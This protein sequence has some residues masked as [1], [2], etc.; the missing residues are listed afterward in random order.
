MFFLMIHIRNYTGYVTYGSDSFENMKTIEVNAT[1]P[2]ASVF[3]RFSKHRPERCKD[4][5]LVISENEPVDFV[6]C[7]ETYENGT[8][9]S[10]AVLFKNFI[11]PEN[12]TIAENITTNRTG[13]NQ[14]INYTDNI[15]QENASLIINQTIPYINETN[16]TYDNFTEDINYTQNITI[17][18]PL[19]EGN[20]TNQTTN[21]SLPQINGTNETIPDNIRINDTAPTEPEEQLNESTTENETFIPDEQHQNQTGDS[22]YNESAEEPE[23]IEPAPSPAPNESATEAKEAQDDIL[24]GDEPAETQENESDPA[25]SITGQILSTMPLQKQKETRTYYIYY[26]KII[27]K[28]VLNETEIE[29][30]SE[31]Q[32]TAE[33]GKP[34]EWTKIIRAKN[35]NNRPVDINIEFETPTIADNIVATKKGEDAQLTINT[36]KVSGI[37]THS[38]K[39]F[40]HFTINDKL[41]AEQESHYKIKYYTPAPELSQDRP[42][43]SEAKWTKR[44][45]VTST[46]NIHYM[47]ILTHIYINET[48][49]A[50][51]KLYHIINNTKVE[52]TNSPLYNVQYIDTNNNAKIDKIS[53]LTPH[54]S[55]Q[56][57]EIEI[58]LTILNI[59]SYPTV[60]GNWTV[61]FNT[62]G[63]ANLTISAVNSTTWSSETEEHDLKFLQIKCGTR[64]LEYEWIN[65]FLFIENY[66]CNETAHET[67]KVLASGKHTLKFRFG[68]NIAYAQITGEKLALNLTAKKKHFKAGENPEFIFEYI[69]GKKKAKKALAAKPEKALKKWVTENETIETSVYYNE[70]L[71]DMQPEIER[72][73]EGEFSIKIPRKSAFRAGIYKLKVELEKNGKTYTEEQEF[74]WGVLAVNTGK[75]IYLPDEQAYIQMAALKDDGHTLCDANLALEI[76]SSDGTIEN[77]E[78]RKGECRLNNFDGKPDYFAYYLTSEVGIYQIKLTNLDTGYEIHDSFEVRHSV[79]FDIERIGPTRIYPPVTYEMRFIIKANQDFNGQI[80]EHVPESFEIIT[81][82]TTQIRT[83]N[84]TK[85]II[86]EV[87]WQAG[88]SYELSYRFKTPSISPYLYLLGPLSINSTGFKE[89]RQWH[90]AADAVERAT[91]VYGEGTVATP[92]YRIWDGTDLG[93]ELTG[94]TMAATIYWVVLKSGTTRDEKMLVAGTNAGNLYASVWNGASWTNKTLGSAILADATR[95]G[96]DIAY[97]K[98]SGDAM[99]VARSDNDIKYWVWNS[100]SWIVDG[101]V[102]TLTVTSGVPHWIKLASDPG[103]DEISMIWLDGTNS[104]A[105]GA[106]WNGSA[107]GSQQL[108]DNTNITAEMLG[109][110]ILAVEYEQ[111]SGYAMFVWGADDSPTTDDCAVEWRQ[112][113]GSAWAGEGA[114]VTIG[115]DTYPPFY[116]SLKPNPSDDQLMLAVVDDALDLNTVRWNGSAWDSPVE[117]DDAIETDTNRPADVEWET[118]SGHSGHAVCVWNT[119]D[120]ALQARHWNGTG[121]DTAFAT[122]PYAELTDQQIHQLR[123][124]ADDKIFAGMVDD[125]ADLHVWKWNESLTGPD[126]GNWIYSGNGLGEIE[127]DVSGGLLYE[128]FMWASDII[129]PDIT[130]SAGGS[131]ASEVYQ[132]TGDFELGGR[133]VI[134]HN[135]GNSTVT[136]IDI[137]EQGTIDAQ[138]ELSDVR[139]YYDL[140]TSDPYD[141]ASEEYNSSTDPQFGS[142]TTFNGADGNASF[143]NTGITINQTKTM[144]VYVVFDV[145]ADPTPGDTIDIQITN[146]PNYIT[147]GDSDTKLPNTPVAISGSTTI[148]AKVAKY[149]Q[150]AYIWEND[151]GNET[152]GVDDNTQQAGNNTAITS[153]RKGERVTLRVHLDVDE[154]AS[155]KDLALFYDRNDGIFTKVQDS[156][157]AV[158]GSGS[159][160]GSGASSN[161]DCSTVF[162]GDDTNDGRYTSIAFDPSGNAW[163]SFYDAATNDGHT[164]V[165]RYVGTGGTGCGSGITAWQCSIAYDGDTTNDG[166][167]TSIAIDPS[168]NPWVSLW[169]PYYTIVAQYVGTGGTGCGGTITDWNCTI[170]YYDLDTGDGSHTSI[171]ID[172][173]GNAWVSLRDYEVSGSHTVVARYVGSDGSGCGDSASDA[174]NCT[175]VDDRGSTDNSQYT[176]IAFDPSGNA[177]VSFWDAGLDGTVVAQYVGTGGQNCGAG[178]SDAW[179]CSVAYDGDATNDGTYTAIAFDPSGNAWVS[180]YDDSINGT[181]VAKYVGSGGTDCGGTITDWN[182]TTAWNGTSGGSYTS[183]AFDPSGN[184]WVS[185][186]DA[187]INGTVVAKYVGSGGTGCGGTITEWSCTTAWNGTSGGTHTSIAFDPSGNAWVSLH[188]SGIN[189]TVVAKIHRGGEI[190]TS[191]GLAGANG[192]NISESHA[193]M[194]STSDTTNRDDA[195]CIDGTSTWVNGKWFESEEGQGGLTSVSAGKCTEVAFTLDTSQAVAGQ[196]YRFIVSLQDPWRKDKSPW[197]G[198]ESIVNYATLT[199]EDPTA[200]R[201]SKDNIARFGTC[202][203]GASADWGCDTVFDGSDTD[204]GQYT[205]IAFDPSGNAWV[206][207]YDNATD[208]GHTVVAQYVGTGGTGCGGT[209]NN[210]DCSVAFDGE[211]SWDG[212]Y[213][214]I[215][216]D[217]SG[218]AWVSL[219]DDSQEDI[220]V[221]RYVGSG[222]QNCGAGASDA[223]DC[224]IAYDGDDGAGHT[225]I[226]FDPSGNAWVSLWGTGEAIVARYVGSGGSGCGTGASEAW[227]CSI[228]YD[229]A[230]STACQYTSIAFDPSGNAWVSFHDI[231]TNEGHTVVA[232]Y[233]GS[234]GTG[235]GSGASD[236]WN[237]TVAF[238]GVDFWDGA[239]TSIAF[240]PSG[241]AWVSLHDDSQ[242]DTI[243]ARYVGSGGQNCGAGASDAWNCTIAF[244]STSSGGTSTSIAFDPSGNAWVSLYRDG[245]V[246]ARYVGTGGTGC[247]TGITDWNCTTVWNGTSGGQYTSIA[248]DPS[249]NAWVSLHDSGIDG[250]VV[251]KLNAPHYKNDIR[252]LSDNDGQG[253]IASDNSVRDPITARKDERPFYFL[254]KRTIDNTRTLPVSWNGQST[255]APSSKSIGLQ[256]YRFGSTN[257]WE[258]ITPTVNTCSSAGANTDCDISGSPGGT[259]SEYYEADGSYYY[260][261][262][263]RVFQEKNGTSAETFKTDRFEAGWLDVTV[264]TYRNSSYSETDKFFDRQQTIYVEANVTDSGNN[265]TDATVIANFTINGVVEN[266]TTLTHYSG[267]SYR[268]NWATNSTSTVGVYNVTVRANNSVGS[269]TASNS[270][271]LY[272]G[273]NVSAYRMDWSEDGVNESIMENKHLIVA[274][275]ETENTDKL[276]LYLEQKDTNVSYTFGTLSDGNAT[277]SGGITTDN[278]TTRKYSSFSFTSE[279]ENLGS[280]DYRFNANLY[281]SGTTTYKLTDTTNNKAW[282]NTI[283]DASPPDYGTGTEF[284]GNAY[285][286]VTTSNDE[287]AS[288]GLLVGAEGDWYATHNF[289]FHINE[290]ISSI[291]NFTI[292]WEGKYSANAFS[293]KLQVKNQTS[294]G[295]ININ[296][297]TA[298]DTTYTKEVTSNFEDYIN[299]STGNISIRAYGYDVGVEA[300]PKIDTDF[301]KIDVTTGPDVTTSFNSTI[302]MRDED[303]DYLVYTLL[304]FDLN[305]QNI[306]DIWSDLAGTLGSSVSDDRYHLEDGT[307]GLVSSLTKDQWSNYATQSNYS[308]IYDNS[309]SSDAVNDSVIAWVRFNESENITF[310][311]AGLWNDSTYN[312]GGFRIR[313]NTTNA[314][315]ADEVNYILAFT[316]GYWKTVDRWMPTIEAGNF[317][318]VNFMTA[319]PESTPPSVTNIIITPQK[320]SNGTVLKINVTVTDSSNVSVVKAGIY[321]PNGTLW[322]NLI[323]GNETVDVYNCS[324]TAQF[325]PHGTYNVTIWANDTLNN[326]NNTEKSWFTPYLIL[327]DSQNITI[328]G[329][330]GDWVGVKNVS[331][332]LADVAITAVYDVSSISAGGYHTCGILSSGS[333]YCW[334]RGRYGRL[335]DGNIGIHSEGNPVAVTM[336]PN[337]FTAITG[338]EY[339]TCGILSNGSAYCW[340]RGES[341][342]LGDGNYHH[343]GNP[344]AVNITP[345][346]FTPITGGKYHTCGILSNGSAYCWGYGG[347]GQLGDGNT[348]AHDEGNPV[349]VNI[350]LNNFTSISAGYYHTCGILSNGSAYCWGYGGFGQLGDGDFDSEG[351]PVPVNMTP[352]NFTA[353]TGGKYYTCG[354]LSN[355][356]AY[357]WGQGDFGQLGDGNTSAHNEGN[358]VP[359]NMTPNNFTAI[360]A[361]YYHT[362]GILSNGS[363]YCWGQGEYGQLGDGNTSDHDEGNPVPVNSSAFEY[364][365]SSFDL[366]TISL[367]NNNTHLFALI[368]VDGI[369][370]YSNSTEYYRLFISKNDSS[371]NET[372]PE[373]DTNLSVKYDYRVQVNG[374]VCYIYNSTDISNNISGCSFSSNSD[375]IELA[376]LLTDLNITTG[377]NINVT[378]ESGSS[379]QSYDFAPDYRSFLSYGVAATVTDGTP[380]SVTNIIITPQKV[381]NGTVLEINATVTDSS[382]VSVVKAGIYYPNGTLWQN[383]I[384]S[385]ET[386]DVYNCSLTAEFYP[387]GTYN[388]TLW[389]N[390]TLNNINN[391]EKT[392]LTPYLDL[393]D[394]HDIT[395]NG[396][397]E[398]W[399]GVKNVSDIIGDSD[400]PAEEVEGFNFTSISAGSSHSCGVLANGSAYCWGYGDDGQLGYGG[401]DQ[402]EN[403]VAVNITL[404][405]FT[406]ISA[407]YEHSCGVLANGSAYCWGK[408]LNGR[409]GY[410]GTGQ[411]ENPVAVNITPNNF[412]G[413]SAGKYHSCGILSN[414]SAYCW[415]KGLNGQ[416]GCGETGQRENPVA[417]NITPNNFTSISAGDY[418]SCGVL[419]NGSAYC[420]GQGGYGRLGYGG[421]DQHENPVAVNITPN[422]FTRISAGQYHSCGVL[423]NGSAYCWGY[424]GNGQLGYGGTSQHENP[425]AVNISPNNFTGIF[426]GD[427]HSCGVLANGSAYCWGKGDDGRL[428]YGGISQHNN[429]VAVNI[430]P[431]NF[432]RICAGWSHSCG[433]LANGSAYCW[434]Y[435]LYGRLGDGSKGYVE[436]P[437]AVSFDYPTTYDFGLSAI[438]LANNDTHLFALI[439]VNGSLDYSNST[440]Y[441]RLFISKN[442]STGNETTPE[443]NTNLAIRYDY[444]V[445]VNGSV[446]YVYN[447]TDISNNISGCSFSNNSDTI[448]LAVLLT[449]L[450]I[451]TGDN[452][453]VT[454]ETGSSTQSYDFAPDYRSF[455][456]YDVILSAANISL[457]LSPNS[458]TSGTDVYI[459]GKVN[460][461][462]GNNASNNQIYIYLNNSLLGFNNLTLHGSYQELQNTEDYTTF[463]LGIYNNTVLNNTQIILNTTSVDDYS[464]ELSAVSHDGEIYIGNF[465]RVASDP[466]SNETIMVTVDEFGKTVSTVWN[467]SVWGNLLEIE[468]ST[469][470]TPTRVNP[471]DIVY[472]NQSRAMIVWTDN[473]A[474]P[475]YRLW[476]GTDYSDEASAQSTGS[477]PYNIYLA[478]KPDSTEMVL[479]TSDNAYDINVQ[480]WNGSGWGN[481][482]EIETDSGYHWDSPADVVYINATDAMIAYSDSTNITKYRL[483]N[484]TDAGT[485]QNALD[486]GPSATDPDFVRLASDP[487]SDEIIMAI[488]DDGRDINIQTWCGSGWGNLLELETS[489]VSADYNP[490]D[491]IYDNQS[492]AM[493]VWTD[494]TTTPKYRLWN[495]T[496]YNDEA[497]AQ[498]AGSTVYN[499][500]LASKPDS[501]DMVL[502]TSDNANDINVQTWNG[503]EWGNLVEIETDSGDFYDSPADVV[504]DNNSMAMIAYSDSTTTPKYRTIPY[505]E[506]VSSGNFTSQVIDAIVKVNWTSAGWYNNSPSLTSISLQARS[507]DDSSCSGESFAGPDGTS[508]SYYTNDISSELNASINRYFQFIAYF[509]TSDQSQTPQLSSV[510][511]NYSSTVTDAD[512][513]FNYSLD[514]S[515]LDTGNYTVKVNT[516]Y[517]ESYAENSKT[518]EIVVGNPPIITI[519]SPE[520]K[521]YNSQSIW[522]NVTL[523]EPGDWCGY[524]LDATPNITMTNS[525]GNWNNLTTVDEGS[526]NVTFSCN[527]TAGNMNS[528]AITEYFTVD[529]TYPKYSLNQTNSTEAG[530]DTLFSLYWTDNIALAGYIFSFDN[531]TGTFNND[532]YIEMTGA[533]NWSNAT[534]TINTTVDTTIRWI[535]YANDTADNM[536]ISDTYTFQTTPDQTAPTITIHEPQNNTITNDNTPLLNAS[537]SDTNPGS[538]WYSLDSGLNKTSGCSS[539]SCIV[540]NLTNNAWYHSDW[541]YRKNISISNTAGNQTDY[542]V[543]INLSSS[544]FNFSRA[545]SDGNDTRITYYNSTTETE[546]EILHWLELWNSTANTSAIWAKIPFIENNTNTTIYMYYGNAG[547]SSASNGTNTFLHFDDA[548]SD[549]SADY[550]YVGQPETGTVAGA[551]TLNWNAGGYY[552]L[553]F[554]DQIGYALIGSAP[555]DVEIQAEFW[556]PT[557]QDNNNPQPGLCLRHSTTDCYLIRGFTNG[558]DHASLIYATGSSGSYVDTDTPTLSLDKWQRFTI[559]AYGNNFTGEIYNIDDEVVEST[560]SGTSSDKSAAGDV[561]FYAAF[562]TETD[563]WK[564]RNLRVR[565]YT[566]P[567]PTASVGSEDSSGNYTLSDGI[568]N[569]TVYANDA[570]GNLNST[571]H[572]F[573]V[574]TQAPEVTLIAPENNAYESTSQI[575]FQYTPTDNIALAN[576]SIW[577][578]STEEWQ[579]N[580]TDPT[581]QNA[582]QNTT[583][584]TLADGTYIWNVQCYD[585]ASNAAFNETNY[586]LTVDTQAPQI[587]ITFPTNTTHATTSLHLNFTSTEWPLDTCWFELNG[588][589]TNI[590]IENC[591]NG[592]QFTANEGQNNITLWANDSANNVAQDTE[593]FTVSTIDIK[594]TRYFQPDTIITGEN[595]TIN[596]TTTVQVNKTSNNVTAINITDEIPYDFTPPANTTVTVWFIDASDASHKTNITSGAIIN[597][598]TRQGTNNTWLNITI[599]NI[600]ESGAPTPLQENDSIEL[601]Y[602]MTSSKL[603]IDEYRTMYTNA[604]AQ[605]IENN[606]KQSGITKNITAAENFL[607]AYKEIWHPDLSAPAN[608][609]VRIHILS[610]G[611]PLTEILLADYLPQGAAITSTTVTYYNKTNDQTHS[612]YNDTDYYL[613]PPTQD[614]LPCGTPADI[615]HYNFSYNFTSWDGWLYNNDTIIIEYN[616]TVLGGGEWILPAILG[617]FDP[618][619]K[620]YL[621][622]E[623]YTS[624]SVPS[625]DVVLEMLTDVIQKGDIAKAILRILNV[626]GPKAKVDVFV[627]YSIKDFNGNMLNEKSETIAVVETKEREIQLM[628]PKDIKPGMYS[629]EALVTYTQREAMTTSTFRIEGEEE[630][631][632]T[633]KYGIGLIAIAALLIIALIAFLL[634]RTTIVIQKK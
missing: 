385:N 499:I 380:P 632:F 417:V 138:N 392:W 17:P 192:D 7:N 433:V 79:P 342:Q 395:I 159:G 177:W 258:N 211:N 238:T 170:A 412:T 466:N 319:P 205:S 344:V 226:A 398:D 89:T 490:V 208:D 131:Q 248:F 146:P 367:A 634:R 100:S 84:N 166:K 338:G 529:L 289:Q 449:D 16:V 145:S 362:C 151:N 46:D 67:S 303:V 212:Q 330:F 455:L 591:Q 523:N 400:E 481:L 190:L 214:S 409:L 450:N 488:A 259:I 552:W 577:L 402:H 9:K 346:N 140:D 406:G 447:S 432:I 381:L 558:H 421:T 222:G 185:L 355:G 357:C 126:Y 554:D 616:V 288:H 415:G 3:I 310:Q 628:T 318:T 47:N 220:I 574:D 160:C 268:G 207:L 542:Q 548:S 137:Q 623:M 325:Y 97:E 221:A 15:T 384:M 456:S 271:H 199:I 182:C 308:L 592:T 389:A 483:W 110:E 336:I 435:E 257:A 262:Y 36:K 296:D 251:S 66:T 573:T 60:G 383:L 553:D 119:G 269:K 546:T 498:S 29:I 285:T 569:I 373:T 277:D 468:T 508:A 98:T 633:G 334:G 291:T 378:F 469:V 555:A 630:A 464:S 441:Y 340:G 426:A 261:S 564:I 619:D 19:I 438:S 188:D 111:S 231:V 444:R 584:T 413:I 377:D 337:N 168:G 37:S 27:D 298:T 174:W 202:G 547:A 295:D 600:T 232:R 544:N 250:T 598:T 618:A 530:E 503:S 194:T 493:I 88:E 578:N 486:I 71:T 75:S 189:G 566:S 328:N 404:N 532:S 533:T 620:K 311:D 315:A 390:D 369:L 237:C 5:I 439:Q 228:A 93:S 306:S 38:Q 180:L 570:V 139:L 375:T 23:D 58:D 613:G 193:D 590:T 507:C 568:H 471:V 304:N 61:K 580:T 626:G 440:E 502:V 391:T 35:N 216:F 571:M 422:N 458:T 201:T 297:T 526:H 608:I 575:D 144:C 63:R 150:R 581:P 80:V 256:V 165:A 121:W 489:T 104:D 629:F 416:L 316:K 186:Y 358:P 356:S 589:G 53:W 263:F 364:T 410:G 69:T 169:I 217:P 379:T 518:L 301:V 360:T 72:L 593:Y 485:E 504:Y 254:A 57:F 141:C 388:V 624:T 543:L 423:A 527:D 353:I 28:P 551:I 21:I 583:S 163:V 382:N 496:D 135:T 293:G 607:R 347:H 284:S 136:G 122:D 230:E 408:G 459:T 127:T 82:E 371:G 157:D 247:G 465:V 479:V 240:D 49:K 622:T 522:F 299:S 519:G 109:H 167:Y 586:T 317:P 374:S 191:P 113:N 105:G 594:I 55:E 567:E 372:T 500:Y 333:A 77:P 274:F 399:S 243:V 430:I 279:G 329:S 114:P 603:D 300:K 233:V 545:N 156:A 1:Q 179:N 520:N 361:G 209:I 117:H 307:D 249:G 617:G 158:T 267:P 33:I 96:F 176:S 124:T 45:K 487:N 434:G 453:N 116:L 452:I 513:N 50:K 510:T 99:I 153:V 437:A 26:G 414:G 565:K 349:P 235:C 321:Y 219:H 87:D 106:I 44:I 534:K 10:A 539:T 305:T 302:T 74:R 323:M 42:V 112:W 351:N 94:D 514:T 51:I 115:L 73:R 241:N 173:S 535:I 331:D 376:V 90:I 497:N 22:A 562:E 246:V 579:I 314:T 609:S 195:D 427:S 563:Y 326:I 154:K 64:T 366:K 43:I 280:V 505:S 292:T 345:N 155:S 561:G 244:N 92:R 550:S 582:S 260:W 397:F 11:Q 470:S 605:D 132:G 405:N 128:A 266:S 134:K 78:I 343:E 218:N 242:E 290:S 102:Y 472:D 393:S 95:R 521:T 40:K 70:E 14:T 596:T 419:A 203:A 625:F 604:T 359:V 467:G 585:N 396:S 601:N 407:G 595:E 229:A 354:I 322:Q 103:S 491:I 599:Y 536:N 34:V 524:S 495:G 525:S 4:G 265:V 588:N 428:G 196:T 511:I 538:T 610:I 8:C 462:N 557:A 461:S 537:S 436:I 517:Q 86:W 24:P 171:A 286:N 528:S 556:V 476:N 52:I 478:S 341:G 252:Y 101:T 183:I 473:T 65:S 276:I 283:E 403:P 401:T 309:T 48:E 68:Y 602:I 234:G 443:T 264:K 245:T 611:D 475:K 13:L 172:P 615:H 429:P 335:G 32:G 2:N 411:R 572:S 91:I 81:Q 143:T 272:S 236:A 206:S 20:Q 282:N 281:T 431:N 501:T 606:K 324:L 597:I 275:N 149:T 204:D 587:N 278:V 614:T 294:G 108:L 512:G 463:S 516:T 442:D 457:T 368:E 339:H 18:Q 477:T 460:L 312:T 273:E 223:W 270:L 162:D 549:K 12:D 612:L 59:Q 227:D 448:E 350:T 161:F 474:T 178:A 418:H 56:E 363:A 200:T 6:T 482:V 215:A 386:A 484:G 313:Y 54:T 352:N 451:T 76:T 560:L 506:Y 480:G 509:T 332:I 370:N 531:G 425:V 394:S 492:R 181:V 62:T 175:T 25:N 320:V 576:C 187:G 621:K 327:S 107:W 133:F 239:D 83:R 446:C 39:L 142:A 494:S 420:W 627:V 253:D 41:N 255:T 348:S 387:H 147:L 31:I 631:S 85:E 184:A 287:Y 210:W 198:P 559:R 120:D 152:G 224:T 540:S 515:N 197:R 148:N 454:F 424:G 445:Q 130:V 118:A 365:I 30:L 123:R 125:A 541:S 164:V 225:S 213:T 129:E